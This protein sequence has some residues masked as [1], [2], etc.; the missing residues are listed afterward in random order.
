MTKNRKNGGETPRYTTVLFDADN[1]LFDFDAAEDYALKTSMARRGIAFSEERKEQYLAINRPLWQA[2][3][4][5]K[6]EQKWMMV[7]RFRRFSELLGVKTDPAAWDEEYLGLLGECSVLID[8]AEELLRALKGHCTLALATNGET[9]VQKKRLA[10]S[11][12]NGLF[13]GVFISKELGMK[14]PEKEYFDHILHALKA[15]PEAAL[16]VGDN[17]TA[18]ILGAINT[19]IDSVLYSPEVEKMEI[20]AGMEPTYKARKLAEIE[21]IV[22]RGKE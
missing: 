5:G 4:E 16:M 14:K 19:G 15:K 20:P 21:E 7:E 3:Y 10:N 2:F 9:E 11:S 12:I 13:D 1:T 8:G 17:L 6:V 22:W 18:D